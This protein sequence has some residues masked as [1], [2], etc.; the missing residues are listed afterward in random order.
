MVR[1]ACLYL[2]LPCSTHLVSSSDYNQLVYSYLKY[3]SSSKRY[4][5]DKC[6]S[7]KIIGNNIFFWRNRFNFFYV[8]TNCALKRKGKKVNNNINHE[9][10]KT[11]KLDQKSLS[12]VLPTSHCEPC[13]G[14][15]LICWPGPPLPS[16][17]PTELPGNIK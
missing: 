7:T 15:G 13:P 9:T 14:V 16:S 12:T 10:P 1:S 11:S 17:S 4:I 3:R 8:P 5:A 6:G 2:W